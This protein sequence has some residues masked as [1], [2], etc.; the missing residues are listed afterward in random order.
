MTAKNRSFRRLSARIAGGL[1]VAL[2]LTS[3]GMVSRS[4]ALFGGKLDIQVEVRQAANQDTPIALELLLVESKEA[5]DQLKAMSARE[6]FA[7]REQFLR[8]APKGLDACSW[9]EGPCLWEWVPGQKVEPLTVEY[10][11]G[12]RWGVIFADYVTP[13][14][15]RIIVEPRKHF[16]LLLAEESFRVT[17]YEG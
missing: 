6:W 3:C 9:R 5:L 16:R 10:K 7:G 4:Q 13:G 11:P 14:D 15:H 17:P 1:I 2:L 12:P 8:D